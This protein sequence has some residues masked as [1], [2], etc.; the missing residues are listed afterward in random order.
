MN[1]YQRALN[2][3]KNNQ[4]KCPTCCCSVGGIGPTG[5]TGPTG[6][7]GGPT[8]ETGP[9]GP[10]G[11]QGIQG[12]PGPM[13]ETGPQGIQGEQGEIGPTGPQGI[14][15]LQGVPGPIGETGPQGE[16]GEIGP[17]GPAGT[18]VTIMGSYSNLNELLDEHLTGNI[19]DA[20]L[21]GDDLYVWSDN[22]NEWINVGTIKG[23]QGDIGPTGPQGLQGIPGEPGPQGIQGIEGPTGP[24]GPIGTALL[25]A[26]GGKYNNITATLD[27]MAAGTWVQVPLTEVMDNINII[28]SPINSIKLEQD[29][30]YELNYSINF[31]GSKAAIISLMIRE[32]NV[33]IPSAVIVKQIMP[34]ENVSFNGS[35]IISLMADDVLDMVISATENNVIINLGPGVTASLSLKKIDENI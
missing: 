6:P 26:Y 2:Y 13:G 10:Q 12:V 16:Q 3:I 32:N 9:T 22:K 8:G 17:T 1:S 27:T 5:P 30:I 28:D 29:G 15:G 31:T 7:S 19:G 14:Q 4:G 23:P 18:S 33:M 34:N 11:I 25:S 35:T 20:Y 24:T 21:V